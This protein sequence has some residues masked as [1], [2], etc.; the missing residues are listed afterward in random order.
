MARLA[1]EG[2]QALALFLA[3]WIDAAQS[4]ETEVQVLATEEPIQQGAHPCRERAV[5]LP[6]ALVPIAKQ[7][8]HGVF[9]D[10]FE[11]VGRGTGT[12]AGDAGR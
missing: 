1:G 12:V 11:V 6:E 9:D 2:H 3:V 10:L 7:F 8:L 5:A 4:N